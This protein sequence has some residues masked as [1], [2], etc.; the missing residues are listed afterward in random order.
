MNI[1]EASEASGVSAKMIRYYES[2][3]LIRAAARSGAGYRR[4][5]ERDV[6]TLSFI[7]R[8]RDLGFSVEQ[9]GGLLQLWRD[10]GRA[11]ADVKRMA[12]EHVA[13][14]DAKAEEIQAMSRTLRRLAESCH[15]N[16]RPQCPI[17]DDLAKGP[18]RAGNA[19]TLAGQ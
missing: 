9:I 14:L 17:I 16:D 11:S 2:T 4:Y 3:G 7:R 15:G 6:H 13:E 5:D 10:E 19:P 18:R 8:A 1:G 12:L